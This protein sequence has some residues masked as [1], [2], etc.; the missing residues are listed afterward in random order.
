MFQRFALYWF[1]EQSLFFVTYN[2]S[3]IPIEIISCICII[4]SFG[5][6][7]NY[8]ALLYRFIVLYQIEFGELRSNQYL[9]SIAR[10]NSNWDLKFSWFCSF[11]ICSPEI[12]IYLYISQGKNK[13]IIE[14]LYS[15]DEIILNIIF[16][17]MIAIQYIFFIRFTWIVVMKKFRLTIK[18]ETFLIFFLTTSYLIPIC[19]A[20]NSETICF[21]LILLIFSLNIVL[22]VSF[23][24]RNTLT[25]IPDPPLVCFDSSFIYEHKLLYQHIHSFVQDLPDKNILN[26]LEL[27]LYISMYKG[28]RKKS[29]LKQITEICQKCKLPKYS[30][31][32][33]DEIE[34][35]IRKNNEFIFQDFCKADYYYDRFKKSLKN[36]RKFLFL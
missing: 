35:C 30:Y 29:V 25:K 10:I 13:S 19:F 9:K 22:L 17:I 3:A 18:I 8:L 12:F 34:E 6:A 14:V 36:N 23:L 26:L 11:I 4:S 15:R 33:E 21:I 20:K 32:F 1:A 24:I 28:E 31:E 16:I 2:K 27:G 5:L 7:M